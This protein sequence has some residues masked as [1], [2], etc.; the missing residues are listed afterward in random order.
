[1]SLSLPPCLM[2]SR[3]MPQTNMADLSK[4]VTPIYP[5]AVIDPN[6]L[7]TIQ[8]AICSPIQG[9]DPSW[10]EKMPALKLIAVFGVGLDRV[11]V[12]QARARGI[13]L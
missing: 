10:F 6:V 1:M 5:D 4:I 13:R 9:F 7:S 2:L 8:V 12:A 11:D 3:S